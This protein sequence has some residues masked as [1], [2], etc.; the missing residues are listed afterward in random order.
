MCMSTYAISNL[1]K[2]CGLI[3][4]LAM[5]SQLLGV[6]QGDPAGILSGDRPSVGI[7]VINLGNLRV[8]PLYVVPR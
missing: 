2:S 8:S 1:S 3:A 4:P 5:L 7:V 6:Y